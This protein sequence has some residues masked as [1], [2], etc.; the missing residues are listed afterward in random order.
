M[1]L[2]FNGEIY[3][4]RALRAELEAAGHRFAT[5][6]DGEVIVA[7]W[8]QWGRGVLDRLS[9]M[10]AFALW[11]RGRQE[12]FL[13]RDHLGVKPLYYAW[14][15]ASL[16]F[17][18][19]L[20]A[21]L[22]FPGLP[23]QIDADALMLYLECQYIPA[24]RTVYRDVHKLPPGHW[25]SLAE[26]KLATGCYWRPSYVPKHPL[27]LPQAVDGLERELS[28]S[29]E[30]MLVA[31]VPLGAFVSGGVDS[32]LIA[33]MATRIRGGPIDT[34]NLGFTGTDVGSEHVE[35]ATVARHIG[36][37]HHCLMLGPDDV[38]PALDRWVE[39]FDEPFGDQAALPTMLLAEY[40]RREVTVV[41]TG[42]GADEVFGGYRNYVKRVRGEGFTR[43][44]G[45]PGSPLPWL[46]RRLPPRIARDRLLKAAAEPRERRYATIPNIY[47]SL[48]RREYFTDR[49]QRARHGADRRQRRGALPAVRF[50]VVPRPPARHRRAPVAARRPPRQGRPGD[51]GVLAGGA[52]PVPRPRVLRLV[53]AAPAGAQDRRQ[54]AQGGAEGAGRALPAGAKSSTA[55]SRGS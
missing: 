44:L 51:D 28:R 18:S 34:F 29:I 30:S 2:V 41:L 19:E 45:A 42:E 7:G 21:L 49:V 48:R 32:G 54:R 8:Q 36:A 3:N 43:V 4:F 47:E 13:A 12:L 35:A 1:A 11:D 24:P 53:R 9:G 6:G 25:L 16:V 38:L 33:A 26:G 15:D 17:G 14:H 37:R 22:P 5:H 39:V 20:K 10:F 27:S 55:P 52:G 31:D 40:A 23:R 46:V 50:A